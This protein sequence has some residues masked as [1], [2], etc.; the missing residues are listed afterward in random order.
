MTRP[1]KQTEVP[2]PVAIAQPMDR[3]LEITTTPDSLRARPYAVSEV[4]D[5]VR[6]VLLREKRTLVLTIDAK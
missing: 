5:K 2:I 1:K 6:E 3:L 4:I